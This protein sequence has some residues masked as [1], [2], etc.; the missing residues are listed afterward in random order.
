M[1]GLK[2]SVRN[3]IH[4]SLDALPLVVPHFEPAADLHADVDAD[5]ITEQDVQ[6]DGIP[7]ALYEVR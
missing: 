7:P 2:F 1:N 6:D 5:P 3:N 4:D